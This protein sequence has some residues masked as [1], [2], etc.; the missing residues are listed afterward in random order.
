MMPLAKLEE[1]AADQLK[2]FKGKEI[3]TQREIRF[4]K[5]L[6]TKQIT[7]ISG[8][9]RSGKSTLLA[10]FSKKYGSFYYINFDDERLID[11]SVSDFDTLMTAFQKQYGAKTVF[12]DEI[13]NIAQWER[14]VRRIHDEGYKI[15]LTG[16]N[17]KLLSSELATHLTGRYVKIELYPFSFREFLIFSGIDWTKKGSA[18]RAEVLRAFDEYART[19]G[20]PEFVKYRDEEFLKRI[21]DD[22]LYR[23]LLTRFRIREV[24]AF[25]QLANFLFANIAKEAS[26][27]AIKNALGF[28]S[29]MSVKNYMEFMEESFLFFE[30]RKYDPSL[31]KQF[32]SNK[33][34]YGIDNGMRNTVAFYSSEDE[35][36]LLENLVFIELKRRGFDPFYFKGKRECDFIL[37]EKNTIKEAIQVA[38]ALNK[39][40]SEREIE[41]LF[42][43]SET[44]GPGSAFILTKYEEDI[45][46]IKTKSFIVKPIWKWLL[47]NP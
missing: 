30:M 12:L 15:F 20:F 37:K 3:G 10:Q 7:V 23:D 18:V 43:A 24:K 33:K 47:E 14:F 22:I 9:R 41:G 25:K 19:G 5:Y 45:I 26:Y 46:K 32:V 11:F 35:G 4:E 21:Y 1:V 44:L 28:K 39:Q 16:S 40:N 29:V 38:A 2:Y 6:E 36:R 17:A 31:K 13:Q 42:E 8:I 34:I 27:N